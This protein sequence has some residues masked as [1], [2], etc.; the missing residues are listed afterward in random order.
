MYSKALTL[1][2]GVAI[3]QFVSIPLRIEHRDRAN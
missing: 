3:P 1:S 2:N